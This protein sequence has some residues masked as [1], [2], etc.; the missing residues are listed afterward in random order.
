MT[1]RPLPCLLAFLLVAATAR[2]APSQ[3][4]QASAPA[5][6]AVSALE[7]SVEALAA[8]HLAKPGSAGLSIAIARH[9]E[10]VLARGYGFADMEFD[11]KADENTLF[12]IGSVTKQFTSAL[13]MR[14]VEQKKL[15]LDDDLSQYVPDFPLQGHKV[16]IRQ[17]LNHTS[18]IPSYT[19]IGEEWEKKWPLELTDEELLA[20]VKDK[21][22]DF[23]PGAQWA[24][25]NTGY[26]L[27]GM[28]L[29]K[30]SGKSY[31]KLIANEICKP[32][33]LDRTRTD[34]NVDLIKNRAQGYAYRKS[35]FGGKLVNDQVLGTSQPGAA[36]MLLSTAR[37]LVQWQ[38]AF[39][40]GKVV[41]PESFAL[42]RTHTIPGDG[43]DSA[44][45][46]GL[47]L[48]EYEGRERVQHGGGIFGFNSMLAWYPADDLHIA[49]ISNGEPVSSSAI[50]DEL[51]WIALGIERPPVKDE[52]IPAERLTLLAGT[53]VVAALG[54]DTDVT[55]ADGKLYA[56]AKAPGQGKFRL[57][58]QGGD[59]FRA[60]FDRN[61]V[62]RFA[63]D[64]Q[65]FKLFQGGG[66][67]EGRRKP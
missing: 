58:W 39:T 57:Q 56:Q 11:V 33:K 28:V 46:F 52:P 53:Y 40:S 14:M 18:G 61:V 34:S 66:V 32:L 59:E 45:G 43:Q 44:Y 42:M 54:V 38:I 22:F 31:E 13:V 16:T 48:N 51:V 17:L 21:P 41:S 24:Y 12:R 5:P 50:A 64:G 63:A 35:P 19:D 9:G 37:E 65:S 25:N 4:A 29:E 60:D 2:V 47:M 20:L 30:V 26:Y 55:T 8:R 23:E 67:F 62:V 7:A 15:A 36:G 6:A 1:P 10:V 27:L 49:V 3:T